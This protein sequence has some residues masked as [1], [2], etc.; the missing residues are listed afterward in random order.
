MSTQQESEMY[1]ISLKTYVIIDLIRSIIALISLPI[2][3]SVEHQRK[4]G[5]MLLS[6]CV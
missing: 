1:A 3:F 6:S 4:T 5:G 2:C